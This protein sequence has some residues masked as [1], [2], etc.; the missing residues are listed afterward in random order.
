MGKSTYTMGGRSKRTCAFDGG[1]VKFLLLWYVRT[2]SYPQ[3]NQYPHP[4]CPTAGAQ[5][6]S[7]TKNKPILSKV[8]SVFKISR[9]P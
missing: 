4:R 7:L 3:V 8:F 2:L 9:P 6:E 5:G 1:G